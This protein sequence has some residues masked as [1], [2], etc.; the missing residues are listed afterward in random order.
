MTKSA[1]GHKVVG[2]NFEKRKQPGSAV[3]DTRV[4]CKKGLCNT[5]ELK[6]RIA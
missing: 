5:E 1:G 4:K 2:E 3:I 6:P